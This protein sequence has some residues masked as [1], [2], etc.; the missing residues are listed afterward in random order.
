[1]TAPSF[2]RL[3]A[4]S[5]AQGRNRTADTGIFNPP[6]DANLSVKEGHFENTGRYLDGAA[7]P[8]PEPAPDPDAAL[9]AAIKVAINAGMVER[10]RALLDVLKP[11][12]VALPP[13]VN[14]DD[15]RRK[16]GAK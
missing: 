7:A 3:R 5:R 15:A 4:N 12:P 11:A 16:N 2:A 6:K 1:M 9:K 10:A 8:D 13:V 14:L